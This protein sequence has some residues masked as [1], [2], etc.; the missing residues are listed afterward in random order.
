MGKQPAFQFYPGDWVQDTRIL[1]P[2]TRGIWIDMLCFMWR[3][4]E[5]GKLEMTYDQYARLLSCEASEVKTAI[6]EL[7]ATNIADVKTGSALHVTGCNGF[8][9]VINRR[10]YREEKER[11]LTRSRVQKFRETAVKRKS[12]GDVTRT[13]SSTCT[14]VHY[15]DGTFQVPVEMKNKWQEAY[16]ALNIDGEIKKMAAWVQAN[17]KN[18]KSHWERFMVSWLSRAQDKAPAMGNGKKWKDDIPFL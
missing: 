14:K 4:I 9:T 13:T 7:Q 6:E 10:M 18:K 3:A 8:V 12:N 5:R 2:L 1:T 17:P 16:P 11:K 15:H